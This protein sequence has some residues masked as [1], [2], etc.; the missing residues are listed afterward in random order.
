MQPILI[1]EHIK[2]S[3]PGLFEE[4]LRTRSVKYEIIHPNE[5]E[6]VPAPGDIGYTSGLCFCGGMESVANPTSWMEDEINLIRAAGAS[7]KPV[8]GHCLGGQLISKAL[9]GDVTA[10][11][12]QEFG[13]SRLHVDRNPASAE[14]LN[15]LP[16]PLFAMQWHNDTFTVPEGAIRILTGENCENQAFVHGDM[17]AMQFHVEATRETIRSWATELVEHHPPASESVQTGREIMEC[18]EKNYAISKQLADQLYPR[19]LSRVRN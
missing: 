6:E 18:L 15:N 2:S 8:I 11:H 1:F 19:W 7:G 10:R 13:W 12:Q 14:W 9:G 3:G 16:G 4:F 17:L 5:G